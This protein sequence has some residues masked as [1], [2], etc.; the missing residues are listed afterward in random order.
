MSI[1]DQVQQQSADIK[2]SQSIKSLNERLL[3]FAVEDFQDDLPKTRN[4][5]QRSASHNQGF[6]RSSSSSAIN[7]INTK[8]E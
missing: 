7:L 3:Q 8:A 2:R 1:A 6:I 4:G 5:N